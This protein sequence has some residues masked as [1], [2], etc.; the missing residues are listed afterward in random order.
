MDDLSAAYG[1]DAEV[2]KAQL[3]RYAEAVQAFRVRYGPGPALVFRAPGRVNLIGEH[4][5]YSQGYVLPVALDRDVLMVVRPRADALIRLA[6]IETSYAPCRFPVV[7]SVPS[8]P[9]GHWSNYARG[10]AQL[11]ASE[12]GLCWGMDA[13]ICGQ[14]PWGVPRGAGLSSSSALTVVVALALNQIHG[15][16]LSS[17]DL[18]EACGR[19]EWYVGTR[20]GIMDQFV[21]LLSKRGSALFLDCRPD[22][23]GRYAMR[24]V[25]LPEDH[26][27]VVVD[28]GVKHANTGPLFNTRVAEV[29]AGVALLR[30]SLPG[31]QSLRDLESYPLDTLERLLPERITIAELRGRGI[32]L[33]QLTNG[34]I[35]PLET[36]LFIRA[37][38]RHVVTENARVIMAVSALV[39]GDLTG[40][41]A[42]MGQS[43]ESL[44]RDFKVSTPEIEA[45]VLA[46]SAQPGVRGMRLTGAGWGGCVV[47]LVSREHL[48]GFVEGIRRAY[49]A[50]AGR[51]A[52]TLVARAAPGAAQVMSVER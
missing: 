37:R 1:D 26:A 19:A 17:L 25:P 16:G 51:E 33:A 9:P 44:R 50:Q 12:H 2:L 36:E 4:T 11:L 30:E 49:R 21:S 10:A 22:V 15:L 5:D 23:Q 13:L 46:A 40:F 48:P 3:A 42:L 35:I 20:G 38:C 27:L 32:T 34:G 18:A 52:R 29:R 28:S 14:E 24:H 39:S 6:N 7:P 8:A 43:H 45:L 47:A 41:G 31:V